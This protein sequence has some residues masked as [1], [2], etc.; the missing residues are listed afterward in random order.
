LEA[1]KLRD[2]IAF[3][4]DPFTSVSLGA[5]MFHQKTTFVI[6]AGASKEAGLP[7][8]EELA[9]T[10]AS[11]MYFEFDFGQRTKGD[12]VFLRAMAN[13]SGANEVLN[14][15]LKAARQISTG[16]RRVKSIDNYIDT[17]RND[18]RIATL[19]KAAIAYS[20]L[21]AEKNSRLWI[22]PHK[23][24]Q[25]T[26]LNSLMDTW[27]VR[28]GQQLVEQ[29]SVSD[30]DHI[31]NNVTIVCFNYDRCIEE[32]LAYW[33][34]AVY[35]IDIQRSKQIVATLPIVR[36]YGKVADLATLP[37]GDA[38]SLSTVFNY[39]ENINTYSEQIQDE[40][41]MSAIGSAMSKA[42]VIVFLGFGFNPPNMSVLKQIGSWSARRIL[43]S[44][45]K[46]SENDQRDIANELDGMTKARRKVVTTKI[47]VNRLCTCNGLFVEYSRAFKTRS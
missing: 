21:Q 17:H 28:F 42:E 47:D 8:G 20:I 24:R 38:S 18:E 32:F 43:A 26:P 5:A 22:D 41:I 29:V 30:L 46:F 45:Y 35:A 4:G 15:H 23:S 34:T 6:G 7:V 33:L 10:I 40:T 27:Y 37:F 31:F 12:D 13:F 14:A 44:A 3:S 1:L 19:G 39:I 9:E 16:V 36:L 2:S 25:A 11:L